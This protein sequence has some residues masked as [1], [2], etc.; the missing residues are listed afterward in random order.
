[1]RAYLALGSNLGDRLAYLQSAVDGLAAHADVRV[2]AVSAVY[3]T[4]PIGPDQPDYLNAAV[5]VDT[6]CEAQTL[7]H[8]AQSLET[9]AHRE[10]LVHWGPRTLDVDILWFG[11]QIIATSELEVPHPRMYERSFVLAPLHDI[12]PDLAELPA[13]GMWTGV[14]RTTYTL[15]VPD[16]A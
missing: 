16:F 5:A 10:R 9:N 7:L 2:T 4:A 3:E 13:S 14:T 15:T 1:M 6:Q 11:G 8:L 12:A